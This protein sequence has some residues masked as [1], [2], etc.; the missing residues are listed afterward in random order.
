MRNDPDA[1][2]MA[3]CAPPAE[4]AQATPPALQASGSAP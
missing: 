3:V 2:G 1:G 4:E